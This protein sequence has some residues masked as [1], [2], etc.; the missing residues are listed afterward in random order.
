MSDSN[1]LNTSLLEVMICCENEGVFMCNLSN[2]TC[3]SY[4]MLGGLLSMYA[5]SSLLLGT[6]LDR[7]LQGYSVST[8]QWTELASLASNVSFLIKFF[9]IHLSIG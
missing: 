9:T 6:I 5:G 2:L 3:K 1:A 4:L 7:P 8:A